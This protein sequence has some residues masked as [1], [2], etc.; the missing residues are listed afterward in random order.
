MKNK[1][2]QSYFFYTLSA[3]GV[4]FAIKAQVGV[5]SFNAMNLSIAR[6]NTIPIGTVTIFFN[7]SFLA[8]YMY[9][10][11]F[12]EVKK[13]IL[14]GFSVLLF[15]V[16]INFF[17]YKLFGDFILENYVL[18]LSL[19]TVSTMISGLSIGMIIHYNQITFPLESL[20]VELAG[21]SRL[22]FVQLRYS[23]DLISV[24]VS[25]L[26]STLYHFPLFVREGTII[27]MLVLSA[28]MNFSKK[29]A[30]NA[31]I[32]PVKNMSSRVSK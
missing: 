28:A 29:H 21:R 24:T 13:Y 14:Q 16:L 20:C 7:L 2:L 25:L 22:T 30:E 6:L 11:Q 3:L 1:L 12:K 17:N 26:I 18:R 9:L 15:G 27:S 19:I 8:V 23:V 4:T 32:F 31:T 10:T 5:S